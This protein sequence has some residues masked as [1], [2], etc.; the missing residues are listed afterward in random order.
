M[1]RYCNICNSFESNKKHT[2]LLKK[3]AATE[4]D[5]QVIWV[6]VLIRSTNLSLLTDLGAFV[7]RKIES[8]IQGEIENQLGSYF[9]PHIATINRKNY[10]NIETV[11]SK[12]CEE[13][14]TARRKSC[15]LCQ[16]GENFYF[17]SQFVHT[18]DS[19]ET[20]EDK[21]ID[22]YLSI[23]QPFIPLTDESIKLIKNKIFTLFL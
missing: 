16:S 22:E 23:I 10:V 4:I 13:I 1:H 15:F 12:I 18:C 3:S 21:E 17:D 7:A 11:A 6:P 8:P 19:L 2:H 14:I 9:L 20:P 5:Y